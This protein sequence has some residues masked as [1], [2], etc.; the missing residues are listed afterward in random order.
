M[1]ERTLNEEKKGKFGWK[2]NPVEAKFGGKSIFELFH[3]KLVLQP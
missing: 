2:S 1:Y 3:D